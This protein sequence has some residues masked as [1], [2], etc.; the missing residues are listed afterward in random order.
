MTLAVAAAITA[1]APVVRVA[2]QPIP[3]ILPARREVGRTQARRIST[4]REPFSVTT[5]PAMAW[6]PMRMTMYMRML[7]TWRTA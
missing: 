3:R 5:P 7:T 1:M 2:A 4:I 6:P